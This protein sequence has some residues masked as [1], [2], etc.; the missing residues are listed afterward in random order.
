M[1]VFVRGCEVQG[2]RYVELGLS[3]QSTGSGQNWLRVTG[4]GLIK[5]DRQKKNGE[6]AA[7][8]RAEFQIPPSKEQRV[9]IPPSKEQ[10]KSY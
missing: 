7:Q 10:A 6:V 8:Q 2:I 4:Y 1:E 5:G 9:Q 3:A